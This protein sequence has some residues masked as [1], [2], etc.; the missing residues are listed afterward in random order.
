MTAGQSIKIPMFVAHTFENA[1]ETEP[2]VVLYRYDA[3]RYVMERRF[4]SNTLTYLD[5]CRKHKVEPSPLQLCIFLAHSWVPLEFVRIPFIG[6]YA[7]CAFNTMLMWVLAAIGLLLF[8]YN[9]SY[10]E[11]YDPTWGGYEDMKEPG[12]K[13]EL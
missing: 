2:L 3:Q 12:V 1:S 8:G 13:E 7:R 9:A 5:D 10:E 6:E 11:Y 4:F